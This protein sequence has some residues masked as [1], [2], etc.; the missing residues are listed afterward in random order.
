MVFLE[1]LF[2]VCVEVEEFVFDNPPAQASLRFRAHMMT[3]MLSLSLSLSLQIGRPDFFSLCLPAH[4]SNAPRTHSHRESPNS[5]ATSGPARAHQIH[6]VQPPPT[7]PQP[8][9]RPRE[10]A[11][12]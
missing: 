12:A 7:G 2:F 5:Y 1:N 6:S 3:M 10:A 4:L 9:C 8:A 11:A